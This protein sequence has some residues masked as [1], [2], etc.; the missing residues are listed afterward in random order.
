MNANVES[1]NTKV[2][3]SV[4]I[5]T[6]KELKRLPRT[7]S[8][9][10]PYL[11]QNYKT[12]E[13][14]VV[15]DNSPD[16]TIDYVQSMADKDSRIRLL[17]QP[18]RI[19]KGAAVRRGCIE[20]IGD[21]ILYM[22]ADHAT[23]IS[24]VEEFYKIA[25]NGADSVVGIRT[26][27]DSESKWRRILGML[28]QIMAHLLVFERAVFDSQ[29]GFKLFSNKAAKKIFPLCR[30]NGGMIDVEIFLIIH[31]NSLSCVYSPVHWINKSGSRI[32]ILK[33]IIFDTLELFT[34][35]FRRLTGTYL[36]IIPTADQPWSK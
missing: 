34:I 36:R 25:Q 29:C 1:G 8:E 11:E 18:Y 7:L 24:E 6:Y 4:V 26:Y 23:P 30:V 16:G 19:G 2:E 3:L 20:A 13:I 32:N 33:C 35:R 21:Y 9:I 5:P 31:L 12:F 15:D 17:V 14:I 28:A 22:D 10:I 27:Q